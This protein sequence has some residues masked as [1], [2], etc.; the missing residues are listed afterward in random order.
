M[1]EGETRR[2]GRQGDRE[3]GRGSRARTQAQSLPGFRCNS[4]RG[5]RRG[6]PGKRE[7]ASNRCWDLG[8]R[9][10]AT[11]AHPGR[12]KPIASDLRNRRP[13]AAG[14]KAVIKGEEKGGAHLGRR[15]EGGR[16]LRS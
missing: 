12:W 3:T 6:Q 7:E 10:L 9:M 8:V 14:R 2:V 11:G 5:G 16:K 15:P 1:G 13:G 4:G